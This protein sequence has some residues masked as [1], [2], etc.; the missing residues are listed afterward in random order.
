[1]TAKHFPAASLRWLV[2][3]TAL[4]LSGLISTSAKTSS[5][6][7]AALKLL[8]LEVRIRAQISAAHSREELAFG[9]VKKE[10]GL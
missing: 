2:C 3:A 6:S 10:L 8:L 1:M 7:D 4:S 5:A 9:A